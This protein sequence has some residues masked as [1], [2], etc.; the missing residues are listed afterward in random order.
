LFKVGVQPAQ[1]VTGL[2]LDALVPLPGCLVLL[3]QALD[4]RIV[5]PH[6]NLGASLY[7]SLFG[8]VLRGCARHGVRLLEK[9]KGPVAAVLEEGLPCSQ[10]RVARD[11]V[12]GILGGEG[13]GQWRRGYGGLGVVRNL[14]T[15]DEYLL[16]QSSH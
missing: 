7:G 5:V 13:I 16:L 8:E 1:V 2:L 15:E 9:A 14:A 6:C 12:G 3:L 11:D 4:V 10:V